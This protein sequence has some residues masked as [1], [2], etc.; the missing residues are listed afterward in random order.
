MIVTATTSIHPQIRSTQLS[1]LGVHYALKVETEKSQERY[2][3][4]ERALAL[5]HSG[6]E[7]HEA[8]LFSKRR[9]IAAG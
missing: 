6:Q 1:V 9:V 4:K 2:A 3:E 5:Q 7:I 8:L